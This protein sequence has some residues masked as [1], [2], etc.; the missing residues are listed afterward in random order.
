MVMGTGHALLNVV[1]PVM[2]LLP[3]LLVQLFV[4]LAHVQA[5]LTGLTVAGFELDVQVWF[6]RY[7]AM[8]MGPP[9]LFASVVRRVFICRCL[10]V[11]FWCGVC[12]NTLFFFVCFV[13]EFF[14]PPSLPGIE[15]SLLLDGTLLAC[16]SQTH[17]STTLLRAV[18]PGDPELG[19]LAVRI[20]AG[21]H[22]PGDGHRDPLQG[23]RSSQALFAR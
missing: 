11:G 15:R 18:L 12:L 1:L 3:T 2:A 10:T 17:P 22:A 4:M 16:W 19:V 6:R 14:A 23:H 21:H 20:P 7:A 5:L 13:L 8:S 9:M